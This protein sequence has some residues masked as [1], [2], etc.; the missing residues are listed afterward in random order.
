MRAF[1]RLMHVFIPNFLVIA[2]IFLLPA[3]LFYIISDNFAYVHGLKIDYLLIKIYAFEIVTII[4]AIYWLF[5][6]LTRENMQFLRSAIP[7]NLNKKSA[8]FFI[9]AGAIIG[10]QFLASK[11]LVSL[12]FLLH[13][14]FGLCALFFIRSYRSVLNPYTLSYSLALTI[15]FQSAIGAYHYFYQKT[16]VGYMLLGEPQ[17][18]GVIGIAKSHW[19]GIERV[20]PY[21]TTAHPNILAGFVTVYWALYA[22]KNKKSIMCTRVLLIFPI[23]MIFATESLSAFLT[24]TLLV[25]LIFL[26]KLQGMLIANYQKL[27]LAVIVTLLLLTPITIQIA[28]HFFQNESVTRRAYLQDSALLIWKSNPYFGS[29]LQLFTTLVEDYSNNVEIVRFTQPVHNVGLLFLA[30]T[31]IF[32][33]VMIALFYLLTSATSQRTLLIGLFALLPLLALDHYLYSL[34]FGRVLFIFFLSEGI[35]NLKGPVE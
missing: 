10:S 14:S 19:L 32:G 23:L 16:L 2:L 18:S 31:G 20:L 1:F 13:L 5:D 15:I 11:P 4:M 24:L 35:A 7:L 25:C 34:E 3:N 6:S 21:G 33:G 28:A 29:G 17:L 9:F 26:P 22:L 8:L 30:E 27:L 12:L